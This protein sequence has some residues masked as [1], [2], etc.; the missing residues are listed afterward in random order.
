[1][2][3]PSIGFIGI[4]NMGRPMAGHIAAKG[5]PLT[6]FDIEGLAGKAPPGAKLAASAAE[7]ARA[8][9][10]VFLSLPTLAADRA[11]VAELAGSGARSTVVDTSTVGAEAARQNRARL[12][13]AG[14]AYVDAPVSGAVFRAREGTLTSMYA[15]DAA[16]LERLRP[17]LGCYSARVFHVGPEAG[18][19]QTMKVANNGL[20]LANLVMTSEAVAYAVG[21]GLD[22]AT[23]LDVINTSSGQNFMSEHYFTKFVLTGERASGSTAAIVRKDMSLFVDGARAAGAER[24]VAEA[25]MRVIEGFAATGGAQDQSLIYEFVR[26]TAAR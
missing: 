13:A 4:G 10:F 2:T 6:V 24:E 9:D 21:Q 3:R 16:T 14:I 7:A 25:A 15:G 20:C 12:A 17:V 19:G 23:V 1:M 8:A 11:V 26:D 5:Y 18:H 22:M